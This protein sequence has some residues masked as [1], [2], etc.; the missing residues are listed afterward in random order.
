MIE[1]YALDEWYA[2]VPKESLVY[3]VESEFTTMTNIPDTKEVRFI[4][5]NMEKGEYVDGYRFKD[6]FNGDLYYTELSTGAKCVML[7][8]LC[9]DK[10]INFEEAG[11]NAF[12]VLI[13]LNTN[14]KILVPE[15]DWFRL[16]YATTETKLPK[17][18]NI[19]VVGDKIYTNIDKYLEE[20]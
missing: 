14:C 13:K 18:V 17:N 7:A 16:V 2:K 11:I 4:L 10:V 3:D 20:V 19:N 12:E 1:L 6:R 9:K 8:Y 15:I 5:K